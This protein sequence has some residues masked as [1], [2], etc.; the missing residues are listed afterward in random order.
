[1]IKLGNSGGD[2]PGDLPLLLSQHSH[3]IATITFYG[4]HHGHYR[5]FLCVNGNGG[6]ADI[7]CLCVCVSVS[8]WGGGGLMIDRHYVRVILIQCRLDMAHWKE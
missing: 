1:M 8:F 4:H 7:L 3:H 5:R 6:V 2:S